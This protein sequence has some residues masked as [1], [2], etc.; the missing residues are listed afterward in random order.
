MFPRGGGADSLSLMEN[1]FE[2]AS[3]VKL[4]EGG[5]M[6]VVVFILL[7]GG[8]GDEGA[9]SIPAKAAPMCS[10]LNERVEG[11]SSSPKLWS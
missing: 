10:V 11:A 4:G 5:E 1:A 7:E 9:G 3:R 6:L 2:S 8:G